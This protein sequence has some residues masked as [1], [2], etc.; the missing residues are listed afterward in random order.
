MHDEDN[1][2]GQMIPVPYEAHL[3]DRKRCGRCRGWRR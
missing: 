3:L 2:W 1:L